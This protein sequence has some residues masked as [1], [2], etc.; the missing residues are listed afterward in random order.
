MMESAGGGGF[1]L[2]EFLA[3]AKT[4]SPALAAIIGAWLHAKY[5]RK[6]KLKYKELQVEARTVEEVERVVK[7]VRERLKK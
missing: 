5:S 2:G 7:L 4:I 1:A 3:V 6:V